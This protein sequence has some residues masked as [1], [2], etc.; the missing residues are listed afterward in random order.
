MSCFIV[1]Q[2]ATAREHLCNYCATNFR[3]RLQGFTRTF[4]D[5]WLKAAVC[6]F[7]L[8]DSYEPTF[9]YFVRFSSFLVCA[10]ETISTIPCST[11]GAAFRLLVDNHRS[12]NVHS[13]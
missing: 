8:P 9:L 10:A 7:Y 4:R 5:E 11:S 13:G 3:P 1:G 2:R 12:S 6:Q